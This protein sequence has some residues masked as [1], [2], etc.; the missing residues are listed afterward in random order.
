MIAPGGEQ[1]A[2]VL[3]T[4]LAPTLLD[5]AGAAI[6]A[7]MQGRSL[8]PLFAGPAPADWRHSLYYRYYGTEFAMPPHYGVRTDRYQLIH[9]LGPVIADDGSDVGDVNKIDR[10]IDEWELLDL[11]TDPRETINFYRDP[12]YREIAANLHRE[13]DRLRRELGD[14]ALRTGLNHQGRLGPMTTGPE[15]PPTAK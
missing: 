2:F 6:P 11:A 1:T 13:L 7:D 15:T 4:D 14:T 12:A 3:N 10:E 8:R 5:L 9:Y